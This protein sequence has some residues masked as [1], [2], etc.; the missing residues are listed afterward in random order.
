MGCSARLPRLV[1]DSRAK[2]LLLF[3]DAI[4]ASTSAQWGLVDDVT[5]SGGSL[6]RAQQWARQLPPGP[7]RTQRLI[8]ELLHAARS[9][10]DDGRAA[11]R[12]AA[13]SAD[14]A[15]AEEGRD[16]FL[17]KRLPRFPD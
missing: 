13:Q 17:E 4:D 11:E 6:T 8:K 5:D 7:P 14:P 1:G 15:E 9:S 2:R 3:G 16:A 10:D 12:A